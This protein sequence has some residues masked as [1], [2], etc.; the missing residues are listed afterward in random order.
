MRLTLNIDD[1]LISRVEEYAEEMHINR[2]AAIS[3]L[4]SQAVS[5]NNGMQALIELNS[6]IRSEQAKNVDVPTMGAGR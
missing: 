2:S 6:L 3:V 5:A 4:L 1:E